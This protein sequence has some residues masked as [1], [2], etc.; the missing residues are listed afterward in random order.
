MCIRDRSA[1]MRAPLFAAV[2]NQRILPKAHVQDLMDRMLTD[3]VLPAG[4][5]ACKIGYEGHDEPIMDPMTGQPAIDPMTGQPQKRT[6]SEHFY[7]DKIP[8]G[9]F[10]FPTDF[11]GGSFHDAAWVGY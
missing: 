4:F 7:A 8:V 11:L 9:R 2:L 1:R 10:L 6:I 5:G 3:L